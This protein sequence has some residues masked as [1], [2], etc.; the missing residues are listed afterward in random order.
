MLDTNDLSGTKNM[1]R[2]NSL[3]EYITLVKKSKQNLKTVI[4]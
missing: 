2:N 3:D 1:E 4:L